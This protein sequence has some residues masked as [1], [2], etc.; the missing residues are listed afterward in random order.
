MEE[1][2][3]CGKKTDSIYVIEID[4]VELGVCAACAKGKKV[5]RNP[6]RP[7]R[8]V[9]GPGYAKPSLKEPEIAENYGEKIKAAR[10]K[11]GISLPVLAEMLNEKES[12]MLRIEQQKTLPP[13]ELVRKLEKFLNIKLT[14][15]EVEERLSQ[16]K[17]KSE[18]ASIG[19]FVKKG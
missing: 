3:L 17:G 14:V 9:P 8:D 18:K 19:D 6:Q 15:Q 10:E 16:P 1:C 4:G 12:H 13:Q 5:L 11:L 2:E 7:S